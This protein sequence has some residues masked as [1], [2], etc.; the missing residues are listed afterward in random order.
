M[1]VM[2]EF[3]ADW[4]HQYGIFWLELQMFLSGDSVDSVETLHMRQLY[5]QAKK[6]EALL[7]TCL[8]D[9]VLFNKSSRNPRDPN[10]IS[11]VM[12]KD[13]QM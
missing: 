3:W 2:P 6:C 5:S 12:Q 9:L 8:F 1:E 7:F 10:M 11:E 13:H 4:H